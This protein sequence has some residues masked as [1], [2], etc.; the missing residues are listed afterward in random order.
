M[1]ERIIYSGA[2][3]DNKPKLHDFVFYINVIISYSF[4]ELG[5]K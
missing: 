3:R 1:A 4:K 2:Q 5:K